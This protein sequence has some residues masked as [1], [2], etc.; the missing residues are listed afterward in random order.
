MKT[1]WA[2]CPEPADSAR[3]EVS[4]RGCSQG[5]GGPAPPTPSKARIANPSWSRSARAEQRR[6]QRPAASGCE[7]FRGKAWACGDAGRRRG[8]DVGYLPLTA[9][10]LMYLLPI[11]LTGL[12]GKGPASPSSHTVG[13]TPGV[14]DSAQGTSMTP[15]G[16][17]TAVSA[18]CQG[19]LHSLPVLATSGVSP[20]L[21]AANS[22]PRSH[23]RKMQR[24]AAPR[25]E[26]GRRQ[27]TDHALIT[28]HATAFLR[29]G[30]EFGTQQG[31]ILN[32]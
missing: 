15:C 22:L 6:W 4:S 26:A 14:T 12:R 20:V 17:H 25:D 16:P 3:P 29:A 30:L 8:M 32:S 1:H 2:Q 23:P 28:G 27:V 18:C 7:S 31:M 11:L 5:R 9:D 21:T 10:L 19:L 24:A 13:N